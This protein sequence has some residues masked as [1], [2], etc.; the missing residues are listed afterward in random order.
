MECVKTVPVD[1]E[2]CL[3]NCEG[4]YVTTYD[5]SRIDWGETSHVFEKLKTSLEKLYLNLTRIEKVDYPTYLSG[6]LYL[7]K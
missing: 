7:I 4:L 3:N 5:K 6:K 2:S 1:D